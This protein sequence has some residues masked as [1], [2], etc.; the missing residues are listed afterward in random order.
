MKIL[1]VHN[2]YRS[3]QPSGENAVVEDES[4]LL[5]EF[6]H[7]V[8]TL[9]VESDQIAQ[10]PLRKK[11][12]LPIRVVWSREG[13]RL[14]REAISRIRP[15]VVHFHN[16]FPLL[17][18]SALLAARRAG[19]AVVQTLHNFRPLCPV[20]TFLR[21]GRVCEECLG[22]LPL[23]SVRYGC[24]RGSRIATVP[25][26]VSDG[27]HGSLKTWTR[28]VDKFIVPSAF[29]GRKY[30]QAGWPAE[31]FEVKF[32]TARVADRQRDGAGDGFVCLS[33][34]SAEKGVDV[35]LEA[36]RHA[37]STNGERLF[38]IGS[39]E[40]EPS[41]REESKDLE[42]VVFLGQLERQ[43]ALTIVARARAVVVPSRCYENFP[44]AVV[45]AFSL[46]VPVIASRIGALAEIVED[47]R[48]GLSF[49]T[50]SP[51]ALADALVT[52]K[53]SNRLSE[54]LGTGA[55]AAYSTKYNPTR[56]TERLVE[57]YD[58]ARAAVA[59]RT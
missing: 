49:R 57:I 2:R 43:E 54:R 3:A 11:A 31:K 32:N 22:R 59:P 48:S 13:Q 10:W 44:R 27:L 52:L 40:R 29:T 16:T 17:S 25:L 4:E 37:F 8:E 5:R 51:A 12:T 19:V 33:R 21:D 58:R 18:P 39:G 14:V 24:Y 7:E 15:D 47:G 35:L 1:V 41:L 28:S 30:V 56:T 9:E 36:W 45:E 38:I 23:P 50:G 46:G 26:A 55:F 20:A 34:L 53:R 42:G 6:G